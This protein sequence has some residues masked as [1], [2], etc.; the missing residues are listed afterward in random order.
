MN[1]KA[2]VISL[3]FGLLVFLIFQQRPV[4]YKAEASIFVPLTFLEQ[5][6]GQN[7]IGFGSPAEIEAHIELMRSERVLEALRLHYPKTKFSY[8]VSRTR[9]GAVLVAAK[10]QGAPQLAADIANRVVSFTDSLKQRML[11]QNV[12]QSLDFVRTNLQ[13]TVVEM[14]NL[15]SHL[16]SLR[17]EAVTDSL[18]LASEVFKYERLYGMEVAA[19]SDLKIRME[20]LEAHLQAPAPKSYI[21]YSALPNQK[22]AGLPA[23]IIALMA[24]MLTA[25][26]FYVYK[27]L[28]KVNS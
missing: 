9:N 2:T 27:I 7:G 4:S 3:V 22:P 17:F 23:L 18:H 8:E 1:K 11:V 12:Q 26:S 20:R 16:D 15:Q 25:L 6:I 14:T 13:T 21:I 5:Q 19:M 24:T 10:A 28:P